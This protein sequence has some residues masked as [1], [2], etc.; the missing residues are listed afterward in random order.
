VS[1]LLTNALAAFLLPPLSL[2][3]LAVVGWLLIIQHRPILGKTLIFTAVA[4][5][6]LLSTPFISSQLLTWI[7]ARTRPAP[8]CQPQAIVVLGAGTYFNAPEFG[9]DTVTN[10]GLERLRLA[11]HLYRQTHLPILVSGGQPSGG[12]ST[13][14]GLMKTVL[15]NDFKVPAKWVEGASANTRENAAFSRRILQQSGVSSVYL[16]THAWHMPRAQDAFSKTGLCIVP[17]ATGYRTHNRATV[18]SF[19]PD[20]N[21][22][23]ESYLALHEAIGIIWYGIWNRLAA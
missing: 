6:W 1:G 12:K 15:E 3:L 19:L 20:A 21:S 16:V 13:E 17:A 18:L 2:I 11:A 8:S 23:A 7:E 9:G 22:L 14:A 4:L 10:L 5:L